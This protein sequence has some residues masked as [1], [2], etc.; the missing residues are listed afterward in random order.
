MKALPA[1]FAAT[2]SLACAATA[3]TARANDKVVVSIKPIHSLVAAVMEGTGTPE[4]LLDGAA[5]PHSFSMKPSQ[6]KTLS[7]AKVVFWVGDELEAFLVGPLKTLA[8]SARSVALVDSH[9]VKR[10]PFREGGAF[11]KHEH[12]HE[13]EH[14]HEH[15]GKHADE[16]EHEHGH[17][18]GEKHADEHEHE[19]EGKHA[20]KHDEHEHEHGEKHAD[21]HEHE[22]HEHEHHD[23]GEFDPHV[24][25][26]PVNAK[27]M[28]HE[29]VETLSEVFPGNAETYAKNGEHLEANLDAL[30]KEL[31]KTLAPVHGKSFVVFHD[32]YQYFEKR[33]DLHTVGSITI[34]PE[35]MPGAERLSEIHKKIADTDARCVFAEPQ[36][37][38]KLVQVVMEGTPA[39]SGTLDPLGADIPKGPEHYF[40]MMR[41]NAK[42][43]RTCLDAAS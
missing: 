10:L 23:H 15:E 30:T 2:L 43:L 34:S 35:V 29:I 27:A 19:H 14:E 25:L 31:K 26:D 16:H 1:V 8:P 36:F 6:A 24:W 18:H 21:K 7:S 38:P 5:S 42:S 20:D 40:S 41:Q 4:L 28:T 9:D 17:E 32:A 39:R 12:E 37:E 13:G 11:E 33:F 3:T 22:E